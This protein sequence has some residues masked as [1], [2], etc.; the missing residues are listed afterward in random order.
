MPWSVGCFPSDVTS[1]SR[2]SLNQPIRRNQKH[3]SV[4]LNI[5]LQAENCETSEGWSS[6]C[7]WPSNKPSPMHL[8]AL[9]SFVKTWRSC[10]KNLLYDGQEVF[11][12]SDCLLEHRW[13]CSCPLAIYEGV[14]AGN[15]YHCP[16]TVL[17]IA[18][19]LNM[20]KA[21]LGS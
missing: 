13:P 7:V 4:F 8:E 10:I 21:N 2:G 19:V 9:W 3:W 14:L 6:N 18:S 12:W 16:K 17:N 5:T 20:N 1:A 11:V 15:I